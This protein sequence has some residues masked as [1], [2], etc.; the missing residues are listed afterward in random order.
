M[1]CHHELFAIPR[2]FILQKCHPYTGSLISETSGDSK[3]AFLHCGDVSALL[4][5]ETTTLIQKLIPTLE[6]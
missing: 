2:L 6:I 5:P 3:N 1:W 4:N